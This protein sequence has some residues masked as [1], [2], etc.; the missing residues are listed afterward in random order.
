MII[1][2]KNKDYKILIPPNGQVL[3]A[4]GK[5]VHELNDFWRRRLKEGSVFISKP[6]LEE[7]KPKRRRA[8][9]KTKQED[10]S[11]STQH[12]YLQEDKG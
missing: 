3:P 9:K 12:T 11:A 10:S 2:P 5:K 6:E 1:K 4:N 8:R 7:A